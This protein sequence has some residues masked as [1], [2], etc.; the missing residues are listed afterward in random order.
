MA[1]VPAGGGIIVAHEGEF[2]ELHALVGKLRHR[3]RIEHGHDAATQTRIETHISLVLLSG[4]RAYKFKK[5]VD[6][7]FVDFTTLARRRHFCEEEVRLNRRFAPTVY[8]GVVGLTADGEERSAL[9]VG[10][11]GDDHV[12][13]YAVR[14]RRFDNGQMLDALVAAGDID[15]RQLCQLVDDIVRFHAGAAPVEAGG[16]PG[17]AAVVREQILSSLAHIATPD[18]AVFQ[19]LEVQVGVLLDTFARRQEMGFVRDCHGDLHLSNVVR[20]DGRLTPF[21]CIEFNP[22]LRLVDTMAD[23]AFLLMDLDFRGHEALASIALNRYLER[24][25]DY[26]GLAVLRVYLAYRTLVRAKVASLQALEQR[27]QAQRQACLA[28]SRG[29]VMLARR[30][31]QPQGRPALWITHGLS[32]SGKSWHSRRLVRQR[33]WI[34]VRSDVVRKQLLGLA[35][36]ASTGSGVGAGA[37]TTDVT[38]QTYERLAAIARTVVEGGFTVIVDASFLCARQR[39]R[40]RALAGALSVPLRILDCDAPV[41]VL[42]QRVRTRAAEGGDPSEADAGVIAH[43]QRTRDPLSAAERPLRVG[44]ADLSDAREGMAMAD[45]ARC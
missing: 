42:H 11:R 41:P 20:I 7:G 40:F 38:E 15:E 17:S 25:G 32:G 27:E 5:P 26:A 19:A 33:G 10:A 3:L 34:H 8:E 43:Q 16:G 21:D 39:E 9:P 12:V 30:Y 31:L 2:G 37:Y 29:H 36:E 24:C 35:P 23:L 44:A 18:R 28:R 1:N 4:E 6:L 14:M 45:R 13:E 22:E